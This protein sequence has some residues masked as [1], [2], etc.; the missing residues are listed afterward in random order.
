MWEADIQGVSRRKYPTT[1]RR[2]TS[3]RPAPDL[4]DREFEADAPDNLWV[5]DITYVPAASGYLYV[6]VVMDV[7]SRRIVGWSMAPHLRAKLVEDALEMA[8]TKREASG[9]I[10][11]V[12]V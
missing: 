7:F 8:I 4:V 10:P 11:L 5:A 12:F 1:T 2:S 9:V 3:Y 6:S